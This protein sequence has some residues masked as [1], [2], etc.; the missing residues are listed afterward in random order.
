MKRLLS[1]GLF[2]F[3]INTIYAQTDS[4]EYE[5]GFTTHEYL[6]ENYISECDRI[7]KKYQYYAD[8]P[9]LITWWTEPPILKM[10][11][12]KHIRNINGLMRNLKNVKYVVSMTIDSTGIPICF[13]AHCRIKLDIEPEILKELKQLRFTPAMSGDRRV[14]SNFCLV[15]P[16]QRYERNRYY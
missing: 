11:T 6:N 13:T 4:L 7:S 3:I 12:Y 14:D 1:V 5:K 9:L 8:E 15:L 10:P 2:Y 16:N